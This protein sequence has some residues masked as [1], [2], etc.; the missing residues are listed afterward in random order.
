MIIQNDTPSYSLEV[1]LDLI[2]GIMES[3]EEKIYLQR[4]ELH[5]LNNDEIRMHKDNSFRKVI[6]RWF[7][8]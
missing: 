7:M 6:G 5:G 2:K 1:V 8:G 4:N 3:S